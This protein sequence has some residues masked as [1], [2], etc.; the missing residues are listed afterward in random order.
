MVSKSSNK[1][2]GQVSCQY[3][4]L[5]SGLVSDESNCVLLKV[6]VVLMLYEISFITSLSYFHY[7]FWTY[8]ELTSGPWINRSIFCGLNVNVSWKKGTMVWKQNNIEM[9]QT[10]HHIKNNFV[11]CLNVNN[12][13]IV[14]RWCC[15][16]VPC[17]M[18]FQDCV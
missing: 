6:N 16:F 9:P 7:T 5:I 12:S 2:L 14:N 1:R 18:L 17:T 15:L 11:K 10:P 3:L 4:L 8:Q 13:N